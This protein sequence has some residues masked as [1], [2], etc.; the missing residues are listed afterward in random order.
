MRSNNVKSEVDRKGGGK[1]DHARDGGK[2]VGKL[3]RALAKAKALR[4]NAAY[5]FS[6]NSMTTTLTAVL[7][8]FSV[9]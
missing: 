5:F 4:L 8:V 2:N 6:F 1:L 9:S 3:D 7:P